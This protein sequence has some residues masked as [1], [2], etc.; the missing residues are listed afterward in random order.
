M[1]MVVMVLTA[2]PS[3]YSTHPLQHNCDPATGWRCSFHRPG[4][5]SLRQERAADPSQPCEALQPR[6]ST[7]PLPAAGLPSLEIRYWL[8]S[9]ENSDWL[10]SLVPSPTFTFAN[11]IALDRL[12][13]KEAPKLIR[14]PRRREIDCHPCQILFF[15]FQFQS[16]L[17]THSL[18]AR[19]LHFLAPAT[20]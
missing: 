13:L 18:I 11:R 10:S 15:S 16:W 6:P 12:R 8:P 19:L 4:I 20:R 14:E 5:Q 1:A 17:R 3:T 9:L 2:F 7:A